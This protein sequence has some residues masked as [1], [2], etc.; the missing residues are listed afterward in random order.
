MPAGHIR[1]HKSTTDRLSRIRLIIV[2]YS[3]FNS[4][5]KIVNE[6]CSGVV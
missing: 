6:N 3:P 5:S 2:N 1:F 4:V